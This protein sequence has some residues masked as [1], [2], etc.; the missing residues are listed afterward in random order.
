M[1]RVIIGTGAFGQIAQ[2]YFEEYSKIKINKF[3]VSENVLSQNYNSAIEVISIEEL[4]VEDPD[5]F[6]IFIAI[7]YSKMNQ[8][9]TQIFQEFLTAGFSFLSFIHPQVKVWKNSSVGKNCFIFENNTLQPFTHIG[10]NTILWSGSFIGHHTIIGRNCFI[11]SHA[12]IPGYC[13]V[14]DNSFI[15]VNATLH[16]GISIGENSLIGA[17]AIISKNTKPQSAY[18]SL[19]TKEF[20]KNSLEIGFYE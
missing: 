16:D 5:K 13:V 15:G 4:L 3:A 20:P 9:R 7:G 1:E 8:I 17:G 18:V 19:H 2:Q 11:S 12:V 6:E 10:D 14:G